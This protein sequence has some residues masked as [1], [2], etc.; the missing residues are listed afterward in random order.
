MKILGGA[1]KFLIESLV[2][3]I[4][5]IPRWIAFHQPSPL[6]STSAFMEFSLF[7]LANWSFVLGP[8]ILVRNGLKRIIPIALVTFGITLLLWA[9]R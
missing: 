6:K 1:V 3:L 8:F 9:P 7:I 4:S 2:L 5:C